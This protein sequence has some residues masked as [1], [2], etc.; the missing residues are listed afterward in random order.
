L[1]VIKQPIIV[2]HLI[3]GLKRGGRERQLC[4]LVA[5]AQN[6]DNIRHEILCLNRDRSNYVNEYGLQDR[7][8]YFNAGNKAGRLAEL[9]RLVRRVRPDIVFAW[10]TGEY[11]YAATCRI[12]RNNFTLVNGSIRHGIRLR[13]FSQTLRMLPLNM[14]AYVVANSEA[15]LKANRLR[16]SPRH[17]VLYNDIEVKFVGGCA[18]TAAGI[19]QALSIPEM[20]TVFVSVANF[21]PYKDYQT[22]LHALNLLRRRRPDCHFF[23]IGLGTGPMRNDIENTAARLG[24]GHC[25]RLVGPVDNVEDYLAIGDLFIHSSM[26]EGCSNAIL[27]AMVAGL[28]IIASDTGGTPEIVELSY[29]HLIPFKDADALPRSLEYLLFKIFLPA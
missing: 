6:L 28:P 1:Y 2:A 4:V 18:H 9:C 13:N 11:L 29:G 5:N 16:R 3:S 20:A 15:G 27:E 24:L 25:V 12:M 19:R 17:H 23:F 26:G 7:I 14:S 10:G 22:T 21:V 8:R